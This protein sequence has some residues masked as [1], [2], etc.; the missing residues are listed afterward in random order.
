MAREPENLNFC[1]FAECAYL[2]GEECSRESCIFNAKWRMWWEHRL[3]HGAILRSNSPEGKKEVMNIY[4][5][6]DIGNGEYVFER[7]E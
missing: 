7:E 1:L 4:Y 3:V 2:Q 5:D 6:P